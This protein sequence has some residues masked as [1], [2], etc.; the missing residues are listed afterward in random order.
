MSSVLFMTASGGPTVVL[1][2]EPSATLANTG[3]LMQPCPNHLLVFKGHLLHGVIPGT[4]S[5]L[6]VSM[7]LV[8]LTGK[9]LHYP[10]TW[11]TY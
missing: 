5:H 2:Q 3:W 9:Q 1:D 6:W 10:Q 8:Q 7:S 4:D 11:L